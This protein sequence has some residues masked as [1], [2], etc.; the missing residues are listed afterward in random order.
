MFGYLAREIVVPGPARSGTEELLGE[1]RVTISHSRLLAS[2]EEGFA[3]DMVLVSVRRRMD[4][5][6]RVLAEVCGS[7]LTASGKM[8]HLE[9]LL[10]FSTCLSWS[11]RF[12]LLA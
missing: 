10:S 6:L 11:R 2:A 9:S 12:M 3:N 5:V 7:C 1:V 4:W 8:F